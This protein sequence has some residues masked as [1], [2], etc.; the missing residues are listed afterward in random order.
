MI[1]TQDRSMAIGKKT[2]GKVYGS[3][4]LMWV[5]LWYKESYAMVAYLVFMEWY[6]KVSFQ[7]NNERFHE[8]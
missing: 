2:C 1:E 5:S 4:R 3:K 7:T 6:D 8:R